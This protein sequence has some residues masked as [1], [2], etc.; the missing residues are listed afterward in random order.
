MATQF[1][2]MLAS[3]H[4]PLDRR[5]LQLN[6]QNNISNEKNCFDNLNLVGYHFVADFVTNIFE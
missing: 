3:V 2:V 4:T 1:F 6:V 5:N